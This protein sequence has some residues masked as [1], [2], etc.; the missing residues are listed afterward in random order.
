GRAARG[1]VARPEGG[2][3]Q[4]PR[5]DLQRL[6]RDLARLPAGAHLEP[7]LAYLSHHRVPTRRVGGPD[8]GFALEERVDLV[9]RHAT[10]AAAEALLAIEVAH[11]LLQRLLGELLHLQVDRGGHAQAELRRRRPAVVLLEQAAHVLHV[12]RRGVV[13]GRRAMRRLDVDLLGQRLLVLLLGDELLDPHAPEH[14]VL[15]RARRLQTALRI[16]LRR[17]LGQARPGGGPGGREGPGLH[18]RAR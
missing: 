9:R 16:V 12:P 2:G 3:R 11:A 4:G 17:A 6:G 15:A 7:V 1:A 10:H 8:L 14:V 18:G 13:G 5:A